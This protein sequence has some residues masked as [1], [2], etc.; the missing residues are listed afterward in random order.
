M[1]VSAYAFIARRLCAGQSSQAPLAIG[2]HC[3]GA[4]FPVA[5]FH[6]NYLTLYC[7]LTP[8]EIMIIHPILF[9]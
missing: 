1:Q 6:I 5:N 9:Q 7:R 3:F 8:L 4:L 2:G